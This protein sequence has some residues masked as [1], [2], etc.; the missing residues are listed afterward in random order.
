M[1]AMMGPSS[2]CLAVSAKGGAFYR[3]QATRWRAKPSPAFFSQQIMAGT[4]SPAAPQASEHHQ[5][6]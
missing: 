4:N 2:A 3:I 5:R 1:G 6:F